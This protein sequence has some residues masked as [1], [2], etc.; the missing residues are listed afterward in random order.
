MLAEC[1]RAVDGV[2]SSNGALSGRRG[3]DTVA[4]MPIPDFD[5]NGRLPAGVHPCTLDE[6][7]ARLGWSARRRHLVGRLREYALILREEWGPLSIVVDGSFVTRAEAPND[8][9][10]VVLLNE[11]PQNAAPTPTQINSINRA[12]V[13]RR[14]QEEV[15]LKVAH[16][17]ALAAKWSEFFAQVKDDPGQLKGLLMVAL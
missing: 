12:W 17:D 2:R 3:W 7:V 4:V 1:L 15:D 10:V 14:F 11:L 6:V 8:V 9:D 16:T 5:Q 13:N